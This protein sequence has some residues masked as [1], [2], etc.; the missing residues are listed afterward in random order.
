M[1]F[2]L[3]M[4]PETMQSAFL[5]TRAIMPALVELIRNETVAIKFAMYTFTYPLITEE[6]KKA[7]ERGVR[8]SGVLDNFSQQANKSQT[9]D[10]VSNLKMDIMQYDPAKSEIMHEKIWIFDKN[11][12]VPVRIVTAGIVYEIQKGDTLQPFLFAGSCNTTRQA[13]DENMEHMSLRSD[14]NEIEAA[15]QYFNM[16]QAKS[17]KLSSYEKK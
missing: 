8:V 12:S 5:A 15:R 17:F 6:L 2:T 11:C 14:V 10:L 3:T 9:K 4:I 7:V 16:L 1:I 13:A